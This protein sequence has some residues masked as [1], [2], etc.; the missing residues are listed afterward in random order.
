MNNG[1]DL[2]SAT[3]WWQNNEG[4]ASINLML[5]GQLGS[6]T[7]RQDVSFVSIYFAP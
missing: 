2:S 1:F 7:Y 3:D 4:P 6:D 5:V